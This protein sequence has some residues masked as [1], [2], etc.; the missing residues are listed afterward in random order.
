MR[1]QF[2][3]LA[4]SPQ[5][6]ATRRVG[7]GEVGVGELGPRSPGRQESPQGGQ[8][9][10]QSPH[11][12]HAGRED[13][14]SPELRAGFLIHRGRALSQ[15]RKNLSGQRDGRPWVCPTQGPQGRAPW[16]RFPLGLGALRGTDLPVRGPSCIQR[17]TEWKASMTSTLPSAAWCS[18][19]RRPRRRTRL[20]IFPSALPCS[21]KGVHR[22]FYEPKRF[23]KGAD[24]P[25]T[26]RRQFALPSDSGR[27]GWEGGWPL[28][29]VLGLK[30]ELL[31]VPCPAGSSPSRRPTRLPG[32]E[33]PWGD[34]P[35]KVP[36]EGQRSSQEPCRPAQQHP[37]GPIPASSPGHSGAAVPSH[38]AVPARC[39]PSAPRGPRTLHPQLCVPEPPVFLRATAGA[40]T[41]PSWVLWAPCNAPRW[42]HSSSKF[43][44]SRVPER[45]GPSKAWPL[46]GHTHTLRHSW[47]L[48]SASLLILAGPA[49][50][51]LQRARRDPAGPFPGSWEPRPGTGAGRQK[52]S[53]LE[54]GT[55][56]GLLPHAPSRLL[57]VPAPAASEPAQGCDQGCLC[58]RTQSWPGSRSQQQAQAS[59]RPGRG[60]QAETRLLCVPAPRALGTG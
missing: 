21:L 56:L 22:G 15:S 46:L 30:L 25:Q 14:A 39:C 32:Q 36:R 1:R 26:R 17:R 35:C 55:V 58:L 38:P 59:G 48:R 33:V 6:P 51:T 24:Y 5:G 2:E 28:G 16:A 13:P 11:P 50:C 20:L 31:E 27:E 19:R 54:E 9:S 23:H 52:A 10:P 43:L 34:G 29:G 18:C 60:A 40:R 37:R 42:G 44:L 57:P 8:I 12:A 47:A 4:A 49:P 7:G 41:A 45:N 53:P 3:I